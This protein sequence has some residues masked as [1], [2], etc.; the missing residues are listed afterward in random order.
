MD[1]LAG[2]PSSYIV[3]GVGGIFLL[4]GLALLAVQRL[5][6]LNDL[7]QVLCGFFF[8][9]GLALAA[10]G[11]AFNVEYTPAPIGNALVRAATAATTPDRA[12]LGTTLANDVFDYA[13]AMRSRPQYTIPLATILL[14]LIYCLASPRWFRWLFG[15]G[16]SLGMRGLVTALLIPLAVYAVGNYTDFG[17]FRYGTYFN[18]Y[19]FYHYYIGTKY[20][21]EV[22]YS[23]MYNASLIAD[24]ETGA[25]HKTGKATIRDLSDGKHK[26]KDLFL[27]KR[28]EYKALFTPARWQEFLKDIRFFKTELTAGRWN[29]MLSDKGYNGTPYWSM[30]VGGLL[31]QNVDTSDRTGMMALALLDPLLIVI[32]AL[33]VWRA[34]GLRA[35]LLMV[36]LLG[37]SYVMKYSHMKGAYLR[38]DFAMS[39]VIAV[40]MLK[41]NHYRT[42]GALMM[43]A[44]MSRVF[45]AVFFFGAGVKLLQNVVLHWRPSARK[46]THGVVLAIFLTAS[47][48]LGLHF[49]APAGWMS[50]LAGLTPKLNTLLHGDALVICFEIFLSLLAALGLT[51]LY[52]FNE[53]PACRP[54]VRLFSTAL[55]VLVLFSAAVLADPRT[56]VPYVEDFSKKIGRHLSD[57]SPWRVGYKYLF[58]NSSAI[59]NERLSLAKAEAPEAGASETSPPPM[60]QGDTEDEP[61]IET[62]AAATEKPAEGPRLDRVFTDTWLDM[63]F[64]ASKCWKNTFANLPENP[65]LAAV[66]AMSKTFTRE[67]FKT[68][69]ASIRGTLYDTNK[70][71]WQLTMLIVLLISFV[72]VLGLKDHEALAWS[73]VPTFFLVAPT[74]YYYI[75]LLIPLLFFTSA[76]ERPSR[77]IGAILLIAAAMPGYMLYGDT[78]FGNLGYGQQFTT[79]YWHSV[80]Y[81]LI[82]G[83]MVVLAYW[84]TLLGAVRWAT[85]KPTPQS[86]DNHV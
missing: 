52:L 12:N 76:L 59:R 27:K 36:I 38:T 80:M 49:G 43:Y 82:A 5:R 15:E 54:Y 57:M 58:V 29:G 56:G 46:L 47:F 10:L 40:C 22:G 37:T 71:E 13:A 17:K 55:A 60:Q 14:L 28:D 23:N 45:P 77:L 32:A 33:C 21:P 81:L 84:D 68:Y 9:A 18:A 39:L 78:Y 3:L 67:F 62:T 42:A 61:Q 51:A 11:I 1:G 34:F 8:G 31:S 26:K 85:G 20:A 2:L 75:M 74:Y 30:L 24:D 79:Y 6:G 64:A 65:S 48:A 25:R 66:A 16:L 72:A 69:V 83:Y 63:Q 4:L 35:M 86:S 44:A 53:A 73:F 19:E 50:T 70:R 7:G 41:R